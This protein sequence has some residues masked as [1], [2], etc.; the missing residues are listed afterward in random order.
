MEEK[1]FSHTVYSVL[2]SL[3]WS[4]V[5]TGL[6]LLAI[7]VVYL[8]VDFS[9]KTLQL[10]V[11]VTAFLSVLISNVIISA[12]LRK[13]G[14]L[15]GALSGL[16][17]ALTLYITGFLAF[18]FPGFNKG[19]LVTALISILSGGIGGIIGVNIKR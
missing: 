5:I 14:L 19:L 1:R 6:A 13:N 10:L 11:S 2:S 8:N 3:L 9:E 7:S 18:G 12:R 17:Y 4:L 15:I 16:S